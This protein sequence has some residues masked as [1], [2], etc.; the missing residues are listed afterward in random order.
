MNQVFIGA[1]SRKPIVGQVCRHSILRRS[2]RTDVRLIDRQDMTDRGLYWRRSEFVGNMEVDTSDRKPFSTEF[3]F[4]RFLTPFLAGED[5]TWALFCDDDFLF[6]DDISRLFTYAD[7]RYAVMCVKHRH[8]PTEEI[9]MNSKVQTIYRRKN[10]SSLTLWNC[11]HPAT[12][13]LTIK[14]VNERTGQWL[15][16]F[17][18]LEDK[19]IGEIPEEWNFLA[20][21]SPTT[22][23]VPHALRAIHYTLGGPWFD[24]WK[25]RDLSALWEAEAKDFAAHAVEK[26][27]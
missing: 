25:G 16:A 13:A 1:D 9:K 22:T 24:E 17:E 23:C 4:T 21:V 3:S 11:K 15:H 20:G 8:N 12:K 27:A 26:A 18:W 10:W 2:P 14:D 7:P 19:D 6:L 5:A